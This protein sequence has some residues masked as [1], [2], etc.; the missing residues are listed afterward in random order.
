MRQ[1]PRWPTF[2]WNG[3]LQRR[4]T[5]NLQL[6]IL[7]KEMSICSLSGVQLFLLFLLFS[8]PLLSSFSHVDGGEIKAT[9]LEESEYFRCGERAAFH[10]TCVAWETGP[11]SRSDSVSKAPGGPATEKRKKKTRATCLGGKEH[12]FNLLLSSDAFSFYGIWTKNK[13]I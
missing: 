6:F 2:T 8:T 11:S 10:T 4:S 1:S 13:C 5:D 3:K 12:S 9:L 7:S